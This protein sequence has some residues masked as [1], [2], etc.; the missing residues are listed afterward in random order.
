[1]L[2]AK[3]LYYANCSQLSPGA[4]GEHLIS[5]FSWVVLLPL[6]TRVCCVHLVD[7]LVFVFYVALLQGSEMTVGFYYRNWILG[8][9]DCF[10][11]KENVDL[12]FS[13]GLGNLLSKTNGGET[14]G[15]FESVIS[16]LMVMA[17]DRKSYLWPAEISSFVFF[18]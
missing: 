2:P 12:L 18:V 4:W 3:R 1:M 6:V 14:E 10:L 13:S 9:S 8:I 16:E 5:Q 11:G 17:S 15:L 7:K